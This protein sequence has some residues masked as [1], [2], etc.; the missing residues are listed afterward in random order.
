MEEKLTM[1]DYAT[2]LEASFRKV[3]EGDVLTG[4]VIGV[5]ETEVTLDLK[6][7]TEGI[8]RL[9]DYS[10]DP[11]FS[12]KNDVQLG[13]EVTATVLRPDDGQGH[14]LLSRKAAAAEMAWK[15]AAEYLENETVLDVK[16]GGVVNAGVIAYVEGLRG[17]IPASKLSLSYVENLEDFLNKE[18]QVRVITVDPEKKKLVLSAREILREK[19][20]EARRNKISNVEI[21]LVT[22]GKVESIQPYGAFIDLG[23]GLSGLVHVSQ[24]SEKR[25]KSPDVVLKVGDTVKVK[26]IAVKDG[27]LSL[28]MK[29]LNDVAAE[30]IREEKVVLPKSEELTTSLGDLFKNIKTIPNCKRIKY[31]NLLLEGLS[32]K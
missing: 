21:G 26:V 9:E 32:A 15:K 1:D 30:E 2:E 17:F 18:I 6:Y 7:Y 10:E 11:S 19:A 3:Q 12:I 24:I 23:D 20:A 27:K 4:T 22:E 5:S 29:A 14:I 28:S 31:L 8:I 25:I 16:I 13:E